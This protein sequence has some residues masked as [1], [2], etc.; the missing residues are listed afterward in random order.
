MTAPKKTELPK[1][2]PVIAGIPEEGLPLDMDE[3]REYIAKHNAEAVDNAFGHHFQ[4]RA[5]SGAPSVATTSFTPRR[6]LSRSSAGNRA[7]L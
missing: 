4:H 6:E 3:R 1:D 2:T 5:S 7:V